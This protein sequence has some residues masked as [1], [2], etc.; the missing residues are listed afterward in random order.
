[1]I[2][3]EIK[4]YENFDTNPDSRF[5]DNVD[6]AFNKYKTIE[7]SKQLMQMYHLNQDSILK[8]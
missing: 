6:I 8:I 5:L 7:V 2:E 1:M 3:L 4:E